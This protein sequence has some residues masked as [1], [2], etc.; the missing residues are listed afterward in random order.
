MKGNK[1]SYVAVDSKIMDEFV[2]GR[3]VGSPLAETELPHQRQ[4]K[5]KQK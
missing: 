4:S 1:F 5:G 3:V 2:S